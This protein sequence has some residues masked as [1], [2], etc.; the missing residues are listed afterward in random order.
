ME[1]KDMWSWLFIEEPDGYYHYECSQCE[2]WLLPGIWNNKINPID[3]G[4]VF[5]PYCGAKMKKL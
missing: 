4:F 5:C 3:E 2:K 1:D